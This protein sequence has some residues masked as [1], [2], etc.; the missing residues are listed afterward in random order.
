METCGVH[1]EQDVYEEIEEIPH[2][3]NIE[4]Q[5]GSSEGNIEP[6]NGQHMCPPGMHSWYHE[7]CMI[8]TVCR[9]CTGYSASCLSSMRPD[10]NPGQYVQLNRIFILF[11]FFK[12]SLQGMWMWRG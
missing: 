5:P 4:N 8:C 1:D 11:Y 12:F 7:M 6:I 3:D 10:R 2:R 9:E